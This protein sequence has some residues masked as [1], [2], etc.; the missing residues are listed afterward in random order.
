MSTL[1]RRRAR[2]GQEEGQEGQEEDRTSARVERRREG[3]GRAEGASMGF[4][5]PARCG[6]DVG[7]TWVEC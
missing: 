3:N 7:S 1:R 5:W 4:V 6:L 2:N